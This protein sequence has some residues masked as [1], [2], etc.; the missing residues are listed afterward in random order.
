MS[1]WVAIRAIRPGPRTQQPLRRAADRRE[2]DRRPGRRFRRNASEFDREFLLL[3]EAHDLEFC[4]LADAIVAD[5]C[6]YH[7]VRLVAMRTAFEMTPENSFAVLLRHLDNGDPTALRD[8]VRVD[9]PWLE[10]G[11]EELRSLGDLPPADLLELA[12]RALRRLCMDVYQSS[13]VRGC[14]RPR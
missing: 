10:L 3:P 9:D 14:G 6:Q 1:T 7:A 5:G 12:Q 13:A 11:V 2:S 4:R 8:L